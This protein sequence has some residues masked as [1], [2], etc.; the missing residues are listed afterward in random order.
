MVGLAV[1]TINNTVAVGTIVDLDGP[2][3]QIHGMPLGDENVRVAVVVPIQ[4][5][6]KLPFP[7]Y[8]D[9]E[10]VGDAVGCHVAWPKK[11]VQW[12][13]RIT[14]SGLILQVLIVQLS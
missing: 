6:A 4:E 11:L 10:T 9:L 8:G 14:V 2:D 13:M 7:I 5:K 12:R 1:E 3:F